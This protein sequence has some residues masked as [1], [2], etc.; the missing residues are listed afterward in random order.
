MSVLEASYIVMLLRPHHKNFNKRL[1]K[2][3]KL[4]FV[5]TGIACALLRIESIDQLSTHYLRGGLFDNWVILERLKKRFNAGLNSNL[6]FWRNN[7]GHEI[8]LLEEKGQDFHAWEVKAGET[9]QSDWLKG[10]KWFEKIAD[11]IPQLTLIYGGDR[12]TTRMGVSIY[13][14]RNLI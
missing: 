10:L 6:F 14:W 12:S 5:D 13:S 7:N 4:Y 8:D 11:P 1:V 9:F 3:P 2:Q